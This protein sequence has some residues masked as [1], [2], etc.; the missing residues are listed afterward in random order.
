MSPRSTTRLAAI[1]ASYGRFHR[2]RRNRLTHYV[3]VPVIIYALLTPL[4]LVVT[5]VFGVVIPSDRIL[6]VVA[7][8]GYVWLDPAFGTPLILVLTVLAAAA[9]ATCRLGPS[10]ALT[11][12]GVAFVLGWSLQLLGHRMEGNRPAL[13]TNLAQVLVAPM[14]LAAE[15]G[16][17]LGL[18]RRLRAEVEG[19]L[20]RPA[21]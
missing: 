21:G 15:A 5:S 18:R 9:E 8:P 6:L 13:L 14:Y 4:A 16:F 7:A 17:A 19:L 20:D 12:A 2:D 11:V 1:L 3:G 10:A